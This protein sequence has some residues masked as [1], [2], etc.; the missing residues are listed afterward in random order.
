M[1]SPG[2]FGH[3][4]EWASIQGRTFTKWINTKLAAKELA[5]MRDLIPDIC[6]G[7]K[8][9]QMKETMS[10]TSLG[11]YNATPKFR[12]QRAENAKKALDF[13]RSRGIR[14]TNIGVADIVD[15]NLKIILGLIWTLILRFTIDGITEEGLSAREGLLLWCQRKTSVPPYSEDGVEVRDFGK[16]FTSGL[17][18]CALIHRHRP[19]LLDWDTLDKTNAEACTTL[20][21][22][23]AAKH[24]GIPQLLEVSDVCNSVPDER[25]VMT[26]VAEFFHAFSSLDKQ[27]T[28]AR[29]VTQFAEMLKALQGSQSAYEHGTQKLIDSM[30]SQIDQ[31]RRITFTGDYA[32]ARKH[33]DDFAKYPVIKRDFAKNRQYLAT[34]FG[35]I[36][37][38]LKT[39]GIRGY[40]PVEGV[41]LEE[42]ERVWQ[43]LV[44]TEAATSKAINAN[45]LGIKDRLKQEYR[46]A[47]KSL[48]TRIAA[49]QDELTHMQGSLEAQ[50]SIMPKFR[51]AASSLK[52][53]LEAVD[54]VGKACREAKIDEIDLGASS[55]KDFQFELGLLDDTI[56]QKES[57]IENQIR[58]A[59]TTNVTADQLGEWEEVWQRFEMEPNDHLDYYQLNSALA[60]L[61]MTFTEEELERLYRN[62]CAQFGAVT[63]DA[64]VHLLVEITEDSSS[65]D[66]LLEAF[67]NLANGDR[68]ITE[69]DMR[70]AHLSS[71]VTSF[72]KQTMQAVDDEGHAGYDYEKFLHDTF[73]A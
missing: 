31:F 23:I 37:T 43:E 51:A 59:S 19:D 25:S 46:A 21:F 60:A 63:H 32:D 55:V 33:F 52:Q 45:L 18:F 8:L 39:A 53:N 6:D 62:T 14:L 29:R 69:T 22:D 4:V 36:Q 70:Q 64:F 71:E 35:N 47:A 24:L 2:T 38:R 57:F 49:L 12:V 20:A 34:N 44:A 13:V 1:L 7:T 66:Q 30:T 68:L 40:R 3:D 42:V 58:A 28:T 41:G 50:Q 56:R 11:R 10:D 67:H 17:A 26:Y 9:I 61:G 16:S 65:M 54:E 48:D 27:E 5:P 73:V 15:G 72:L